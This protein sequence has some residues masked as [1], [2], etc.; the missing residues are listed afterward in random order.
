M[1]GPL[2]SR[3]AGAPISWG[4]CEVPGWGHQMRPDRVLGEMHQLGLGATEL[5]PV[6]FL[7]T[8]PGERSRALEQHGLRV[9]GGFLPL[10]LHD[11]FDA[12]RMLTRVMND[13]SAAGGAVLVLAAATGDDGYDTRPA[14]SAAEW[15]TLL[16]SLDTIRELAH[17][18]G[19]TAVLHPHVGTV[20]ETAAEVERVLADSDIDLCLDTGHLLIGGTDPLELVNRAATRVGHVH[21]KD[22]RSELAEQVRAG[23][24]GYSSA[25][26]E[27]LYP[28]LGRGDVDITGVVS[29]LES[30]GYEGWYV[31]EQ[32][33]V[34]DAEP[35]PG[36][37]PISDVRAAGEHLL[38]TDVLSG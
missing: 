23:E 13:F 4:V 17:D 28:V 3:V 25:V 30:A 6:G 32:D 29:V 24:L 38:G 12:A 31:L 26:R 20:V 27:G 21:L 1:S 18:L 22:V 10:V 16:R 7:P 2:L 19:V 11:G 35:P 37:G 14:L 33:V 8:D 5:G 36:L 15:R 34:L 9:A